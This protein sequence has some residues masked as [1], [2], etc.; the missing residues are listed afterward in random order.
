MGKLTD[1]IEKIDEQEAM[2][3]CIYAKQATAGVSPYAKAVQSYALQDTNAQ[4]AQFI[5]KPKPSNGGALHKCINTQG[6][7]IEFSIQA[8]IE[9]GLQLSETDID[10]LVPPSD[11]RDTE[12]CTPEELQAWGSALALRAARERG[13]VPSGWDQIA[14]CQNCGPVYSFAGGDYLACPWC[15]MTR[16]GKSIPLPE[17]DNT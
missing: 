6:A 12:K 3:L 13:I 10:A 1:L 16:A 7:L 5:H 14:N 8:G 17:P 11:W 4:N 2:H 9:H 15:E